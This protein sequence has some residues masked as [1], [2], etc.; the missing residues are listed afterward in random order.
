M[1]KTLLAGAAI[2]YFGKKLYDEGK[3]D[4]YIARAKSTLAELSPEQA[5]TRAPRGVGQD[6]Q[7]NMA[8]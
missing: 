3:L 5:D 7:P 8:F 2:G 1:M 4:P 6:E